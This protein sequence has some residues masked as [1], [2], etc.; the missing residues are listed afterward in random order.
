MK[1]VLFH[2]S[3]PK[4]EIRKKTETMKNVKLKHGDSQKLGITQVNLYPQN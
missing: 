4:V 2:T 3:C 1:L